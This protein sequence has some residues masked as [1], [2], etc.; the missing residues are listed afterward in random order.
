M[1][2]NRQWDMAELTE[3]KFATFHCEHAMSY[4]TDITASESS[5]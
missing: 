2:M 3:E 5:L 1:L 4:W